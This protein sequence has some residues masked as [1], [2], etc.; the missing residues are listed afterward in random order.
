M[1]D[2]RL[3]IADHLGWAVAVT[4]SA[5]HEVVDRR[6]IELI[7][8]GLSQAPIHYESRRLDVSATA[9]LVAQVR[10][11]VVRATSAALDEIAPRCPGPSARSRCEPGRRTSPRTSPSNAARRTRPGPTPSCIARSWPSSPTLVTGRSTSTTPRRSSVKRPGRSLGG[12]TR[13]CTDH[14]RCWG[15]RGR[16]TTGS[17][18]PRRSSRAEAPS[19]HRGHHSRSARRSATSCRT[20]GHSSPGA[21]PLTVMS[22]A[23]SSSVRTGVMASE[24]ATS[25]IAP[26]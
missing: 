11:S 15:H 14:G 20:P 18:S 12:P 23:R 6:R 16:R 10:A 7:E 8:P 17:R 26:P 3:G 5:D 9:A 1:G 4:A 2:V 13:S 22:R 24:P 19:D 21:T 25:M